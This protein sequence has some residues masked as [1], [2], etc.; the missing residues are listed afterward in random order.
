MGWIKKGNV[1]ALVFV[2]GL[3]ALFFVFF[4]DGLVKR[5]LVAGA[6]AA[7]RAKVDI[8]EVDV[9]ILKGVLLINGLAAANKDEPMKNIFEFRE[10]RLDFKL[11]AAL[12]GKVVVSDASLS[13]L[14]FGTARKTSGALAR[15][16]KPSALE[17]M[18][19]KALGAEGQA[20]LSKLGEMKPVLKGDLDPS[21]LK[22]LV[23]LDEAEKK[24]NE[25]KERWQSRIAA[26]QNFDKDIAAIQADLKSVGAGGSS[27]AD[28]ARKVQLVQQAQAKL[29]GMQAQV[30]SAR[31]DINGD[32]AQVQGVLAKAQ[33]LKNQDLNG[34]L[35]MAGVPSL[36]AESL[37]K[38]LLGP[39]LSGRVG[40]ALYWVSWARTKS[41]G[42]PAKKAPERPRRKGVDVE[43]PVPG[44]DPRFL[45][46]KASIDGSLTSVF[47]GQDMDLY[48]TL[49]G[50]T[51][52]APL[53][54]K[55]ARLNLSGAVKNGP[56]L[57]LEGL[58][59]QTKEPG[60]AAVDFNYAGLPLAGLFLGD[61][62]LG[63]QVTAGSAR[64]KGRI[65][66]Q[67]D[68]WKGEVLIDASSI[69]LEP[70]L[71]LSGDMA[72]FAGSALKGV[73]RFNARVGIEGAE[74]DLRFTI[75]SDLGRT[76][77]DSLKGAFSAEIAAQRKILEQKIDALYAG[78]AKALQA[79]AGQLQSQLLG[80]LNSQQQVLDKAVKD[81]ASKSAGGNPLDRLKG[82]FR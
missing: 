70:K 23:G 32:L 21:K 46:E 22:S 47:Q 79:Q 74:D 42:S 56:T 73:T 65:S 4:L 48:G 40:E 72:R 20:A 16:S 66:S 44:A 13:G 54:G 45:L 24:V 37:T 5:A 64:L 67:G 15:P 7:V 29:K 41:S 30:Q 8:A 63:A 51:S 17:T 53:Y 33:D 52:D 26:I 3:I 76:L 60:G 19:K 77:A 39:A 28:I 71:G 61:G 34:L 35:A 68:Q 6:Q 10:A 12:R 14:L 57:S 78:K 2:A 50:V 82:L 31:Q 18:A 43:F 25:V 59:D 38:R 11:S 1:G 55:P 49:T 36:D 75:S 81:A 9:Q 27:P 69:R 62:E 58:L 80:P